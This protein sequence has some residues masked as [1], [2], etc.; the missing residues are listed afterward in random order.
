M[1]NDGYFDRQPLFGAAYFPHAGRPKADLWA[2]S[3]TQSVTKTDENAVTRTYHQP[4]ALERVHYCRKTHRSEN[5]KLVQYL[6][7]HTFPA[8][9]DALEQAASKYPDISR[10]VFQ[11]NWFACRLWYDDWD[12]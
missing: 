11:N 1:S 7:A 4:L 3:A 6:S 2:C 10:V 12:M 8:P 5:G 9:L